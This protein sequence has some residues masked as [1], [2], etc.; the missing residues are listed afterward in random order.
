MLQE[1][2]KPRELTS[3]L[4]LTRNGKFRLSI[5]STGV[6]GRPEVPVTAPDAQAL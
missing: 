6:Q 4:K 3:N 2:E 1:E 5:A